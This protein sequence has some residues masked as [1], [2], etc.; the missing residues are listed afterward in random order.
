MADNILSRKESLILTAI[1]VINEMGIQGLSI[2]EVAKRQQM[3]NAA[4]FNHFKSKGDLINAVLDHYTQY[5]NALIQA[6]GL[7]KDSPKAAIINYMEMFYT[8]FENY[9]AITAI[10]QL[11]DVLRCE[12]E[13]AEKVKAIFSSRRMNIKQ[14][15]EEAQAAGQICSDVESGCL[16]DIILG[17]SSLITL[18]WRMEDYGF[19][20]KERVLDTVNTI[21][22]SFSR[23]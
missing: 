11:Y 7:R 17:S 21:L 4:I 3:S 10:A 5:D 18:R 8:Y 23:S 22:A 14:M 13:F 19:P 1:E 16:A 15:V 2:R 12:P 20:L 9:P 6:V